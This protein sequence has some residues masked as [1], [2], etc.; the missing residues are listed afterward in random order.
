MLISYTYFKSTITNYTFVIA[1][2]IIIII[3][4]VLSG[5]IY[6]TPFLSIIFEFFIK[7]NAPFL[8]INTKL[9]R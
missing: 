9:T 4:Y 7:L 2:K 5:R 6:N 1:L 3:F 8:L